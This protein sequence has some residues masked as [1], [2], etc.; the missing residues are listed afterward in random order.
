MAFEEADV[1]GGSNAFEEAGLRGARH[2]SGNPMRRALSSVGAT[3]ESPQRKL[4]GNGPITG[5]PAGGE[6]RS[7]APPGAGT[8]AVMIPRP[9]GLGFILSPLAGLAR[10]L[11]GF[12]GLAVWA[13]L[14]RTYG[15]EP[16]SGVPLRPDSHVFSRQPDFVH[17]CVAHPWL[18][19]LT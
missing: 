10:L 15:V 16:Q 4:W 14:F 12:P 2:E 5:S 8:P 1:I 6:R 13:I 3:E 19:L 17:F 18:K 9:H 7:Y 11:T